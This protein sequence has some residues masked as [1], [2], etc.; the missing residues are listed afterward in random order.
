MKMNKDEVLKILDMLVPNPTCPLNYDKDYELLL[1]VMLSAQTTD[2]RVNM[3]TKELFKY[4]LQE[5]ANLDVETIENIIKPV[6]TQKR[7][8]KYVH[9]ITSSLLTSANGKVPHDRKYVE[10]LPGVG[11]KTANVVFGELFNEPTLAVDTHVARVSVRLELASKE[12]DVLK[13]E[14]KLMTFF[15]KEKWTRVHVQLV[16]FGRYTCKAINPKCTDCP[17]KDNMCTKNRD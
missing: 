11:H 16:L 1:A 5:L 7:K 15:P 2:D 6:G 13:I 4:N 12:D 8:S 17:F 10:S 9:D 14:E 3:V